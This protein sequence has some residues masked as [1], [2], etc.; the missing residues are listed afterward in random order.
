MFSLGA[1]FVVLSLSHWSFD[2]YL[3]SYG[4]HA[5]DKEAWLF[6]GQHAKL[7]WIVLNY[8]WRGFSFGFGFVHRLHPCE[9]IVFNYVMYL[10]R[11]DTLL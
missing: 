2:G 3:L 8:D 9:E 1:S 10:C 11:K 4:A 6:Q 5:R 7:S